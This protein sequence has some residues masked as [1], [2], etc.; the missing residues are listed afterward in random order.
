M[1]RDLGKLFKKGE[2]IFHQGDVADCMYVVQKGEVELVVESDYGFKSLAIHRSGDVFG[3]VSLFVGKA[4][5]ATARA[6][7]DAW[8]L[9]LD[10][11][12]F[13]ARLHQ[14][15][16]LAFH[17][18]R[19]MAHRI[20]EQDHLMMRGFFDEGG[21]PHDVNGFVS[22]IDLVA[23]V[24]RELA[25]AK[26]LWQDISLAIIE[27]DRFGALQEQFGTALGEDLLTS[28]GQTIRGVVRRQ[29]VVG[30][31]GEDQFGLLLFETDGQAAVRVLEKVRHAFLNL[32]GRVEHPEM[33][34]S[35]SCGIACYPDYTSLAQLHKAAHR[36]LSTGKRSGNQILLALPPKS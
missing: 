6:V 17:M 10:E 33:V 9:T 20:Y 27:I 14:D 22:Y 3:E 11:K 1:K 35:F 21:R 34:A 12:A 26:R 2:V 4:R 24:E 5:F 36:A 7:Q 23:L 28:L 16:S 30:R 19:Q 13:V 8:V 29:D 32:W 31:F 25:R 15:P 18:I